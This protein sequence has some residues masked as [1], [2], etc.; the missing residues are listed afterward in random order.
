MKTK[1]VL[2]T[3]DCDLAFSHELTSLKW[4]TEGHFI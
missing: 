4:Q 2:S 1:L 3:V